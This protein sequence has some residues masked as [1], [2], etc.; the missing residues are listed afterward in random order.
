MKTRL[1]QIKAALDCSAT[2]R[3][4]SDLVKSGTRSV[5]VISETQVVRLIEVVVEDTL[6]E[7][8]LVK[9]SE[10]DRVVA[11]AKARFDNLM[12]QQAEAEQRLQHQE[13]E[14]AE[15]R[16]RVGELDRE[17]QQAL[18]AARELEQQR[19]AALARAAASPAPAVAIDRT[20]EEL[21]RLA[22]ELAQMQQWLARIEQV[23]S[24]AAR[25]LDSRLEQS[26]QRLI[27][28]F[29]RTVTGATVRPIEKRVEAT[30]ALI[31]KVLAKETGLKSNIR[32]LDAAQR[33]SGRSIERSIERLRHT[34]K[35]AGSNGAR[36][37]TG[38]HERRR[39]ARDRRQSPSA[40][41]ADGTERRKG[42]KDRR[43][44]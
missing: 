41:R 31:G 26:M 35:G 6:R 10:R 16:R 12:R 32:E 9:P 22:G 36:G 24:G 13:Q 25:D 8:G 33:R 44:R 37:A 30:D 7:S 18:A 42:P 28:R 11:L 17:R 21:A 1:K 14:L 29:G 23:G 15:L 20:P 34:Q 38:T 3:T 27:E 2:R 5:R 19:D 43:A 40:T 39:G 4:V